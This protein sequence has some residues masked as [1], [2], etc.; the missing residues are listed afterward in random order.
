MSDAAAPRIPTDW[1]AGV[2]QQ[3]IRRRYAAERRFR[4]LGLGAVLL[5]A[6]F[7]AFLLITMA[8]KGL[9]GFTATEAKVAIDFPRSD[10][11]LDPATLR[12]P[13]AEEAESPLGRVPLAQAVGHRPVGPARNSPATHKLPD[14]CAR[15]AAR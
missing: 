2:M 4:M 6:A 7:L 3:R 11:I 8:S 13:Q 14:T 10:L 5:S 1:K 12:G 15:R 9:G